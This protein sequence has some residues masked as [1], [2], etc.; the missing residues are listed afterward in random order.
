MTEY[1]NYGYGLVPAL[2]T[3][4]RQRPPLDKSQHD[5]DRE[6]REAEEIRELEIRDRAA[7][8]ESAANGPVHVQM[9]SGGRKW[10]GGEVLVMALANGAV[11]VSD[12]AF[13][14]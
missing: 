5:R 12:L 4:A 6:A 3:P 13:Q 8:L 11:P 1:A 14:R 7:Q 9:P 2:P 10:L